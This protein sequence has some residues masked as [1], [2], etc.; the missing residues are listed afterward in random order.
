MRSVT[1][2]PKDFIPSPLK[3]LPRPISIE[4]PDISRKSSFP[5][6]PVFNAGELSPAL[7]INRPSLSIRTP[8][9]ADIMLENGDLAQ[10]HVPSLDTGGMIVPGAT[11]FVKPE[12]GKKCGFSAWCSLEARIKSQISGEEETDALRIDAQGVDWVVVGCNPSSAEKAVKEI[13]QGKMLD[14]FGEFD[15]IHQQVT[16]GNSRFDYALSNENEEVLWLIETKIVVC[17]DYPK[18]FVPE[19]PI[20]HP[21]GIYECDRK[22]YQRNAIF[23]HGAQ[24]P[25]TKVVSE[26]AIKHIH[27]LSTLLESLGENQTIPSKAGLL[28]KN[29]K[30]MILFVVNR[31]DCLK[32]RPCHE[33]DPLFARVLYNAKHSYGV[34]VKAIK[35]F[36]CANSGRAWLS[37]DQIEIIWNESVQIPLENESEWLDIVLEG[38]DTK[39]PAIK[40]SKAKPKP[41]ARNRKRQRKSSSSEEEEYEEDD[42][43]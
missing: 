14:C 26:R 42:D 3:I 20:R 17:A 21:V 25:K 9:V 37:K 10:A 22:P 40:K 36:W 19:D 23:P 30:A 27:E 15:Q 8:Y 12:I 43:E 18:G 29:T 33:A 6:N 32:F 28:T 11:I 38:E 31:D 2:K 13:L 34:E 39:K 24:K 5:K 7:V 4:I 1:S 41:K 35:L 16:V